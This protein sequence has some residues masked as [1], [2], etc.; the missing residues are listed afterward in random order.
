MG[1]IEETLGHDLQIGCQRHWRTIDVNVN[2]HSTP[3]IAAGGLFRP[4]VKS[5]VSLG[6]WSLF[7]STRSSVEDYFRG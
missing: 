5:S 3:L 7:G 1:D 6:G 2:H 4:L